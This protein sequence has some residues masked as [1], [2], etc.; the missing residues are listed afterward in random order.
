M[1]AYES[2][3]LSYSGDFRASADWCG[4]SF[5]LAVE[6]PKLPALSLQE[7]DGA[8]RPG[9][10]EVFKPLFVGTGGF[11]RR[12][13]LWGIVGTCRMGANVGDES[14]SWARELEL[15]WALG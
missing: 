1:V 5:S 3:N 4:T 13:K 2:L 15:N 12:H 14:C 11:L 7:L 8:P 9:A 10:L 6:I